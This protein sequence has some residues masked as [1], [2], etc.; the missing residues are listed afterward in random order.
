MGQ[1]IQN[2]AAY[3]GICLILHFMVMEILVFTNI[4]VHI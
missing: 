2:K 3:I 1:N 4:V